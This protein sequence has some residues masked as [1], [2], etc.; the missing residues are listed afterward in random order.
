MPRFEGLT[1]PFQPNWQG[2]LDNI[3]RRGTPDRVYFV[4]L[5]LDGEVR[6]AITSRFD[7]MA[8][9][10]RDDPDYDRW[11]YI[12]VQRFCGHDMIRA[13]LAD[14]V[15][16]FHRKAVADSAALPRSTGRS[17][18]DE[19]TGPITSWAE[20]EAYPWPDP[21]LPSA[22]RDLEWMN[23]NLPDDMCLV[24]ANGIGNIMEWLSWLMGYE[25]LCFALF[26]NRPL[27]TAI[28]NRLKEYFAI[29]LE[30]ILQ[31]ERVKLVWSSD[32]LGF[33]SGLLMSPPDLREFVLSGHKHLAAMSHAAGRPYLLHSCGNLAAIMEE[34]IEEVRIDAKHSFEDT[35]GDVRD[36][37]RQYGGR[38]SLLG[39]LDVDFLCRSDEA[40]I[41][42]RVRETLE[43]CQP[44]GGYCLG[45]GNSVANYIP[46]DNYLV[47]LDEGRLWGRAAR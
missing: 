29:S 40:A 33:K 35:I 37:K 10:R 22:T 32:D 17:Y 38:L 2:L 19:H 18:Q 11:K 1:A 39:G 12:L 46:L 28:A 26:E 5:F 3:H 43:V 45:T 9:M 8:G 13:G 4:E 47:M 7:V 23:C 25:T 31:F 14:Q 6:E 36:A 24:A 34:L 21:R 30:R 44:G 27:V 15:M 42:R 16:T 41:R 20:F